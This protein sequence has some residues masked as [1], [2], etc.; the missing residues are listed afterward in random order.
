MQQVP[1]G[2]LLTEHIIGMGTRNCGDTISFQV[3]QTSC[4]P[5]HGWF[6]MQ[7]LITSMW[8]LSGGS[9]LPVLNIPC[10]R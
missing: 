8:Y 6:I 3:V 10:G 7:A 2:T 4:V 5:V 9:F 1:L